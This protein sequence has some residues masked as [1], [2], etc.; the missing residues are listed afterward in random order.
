M[1]SRTGDPIWQDTVIAAIGDRHDLTL[2]D[3]TLPLEP[4]FEGV[5]AVLDE[6]GSIGT[7]EM[8]DA[9]KD[10]LFWQVIGTGLDHVDVAYMRSK[11]FMVSNCPGQFSSVALSECAMMYIL[12]LSRRFHEAHQNFQDGVFYHPPGTELIG[13]NLGLVGFGASAQ[14]LARRAKPFG[15]KIMAIDVRKIEDEILDEIQPDFMGTPDDLDRVVVESDFLSLHL[16]L[17]AETRHTIDAR[18]IG[19]MKK[20]ACIINVARGALVDEEAMHRALLGGMLGGAGL[21]VFAAEP[22]DPTL[23]VY[24]LPNVIVTPHISGGTDGTARKRAAVA[25]ENIDRIGQ[26]LEPLYRVDL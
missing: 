25:A 2:Y 14:E 3:E 10:T 16:H 22:P 12:M 5:E 9:A 24:R 6:G 21:D 17:N 13:A 7:R 15:M 4:Q 23:D 20:T 11:G 26:D 1:H 8:Y 19:M 18:R